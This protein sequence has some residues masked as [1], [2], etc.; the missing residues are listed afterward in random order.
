VPVR[1]L[2]SFSL[3]FSWAS[4]WF[5]LLLL[6][7]LVWLR[8]HLNLSRAGHDPVLLVGDPGPAD[9]PWPRLSV[10]VAAKDEEENI[11]ACLSG[12]LSQDYPELELIVIN[13]RS[14]DRTGEI[15]DAVAARDARVKAV[16]VR[17]LPPGW[18]GKNH[19]MHVG[20]QRATGDYLCFTDADCHYHATGLL[21]AA[22]RYA[23]AEQIEFLSVLPE[24]EAHT[25]WERV[26]QPPAGAIMVF[27]FAPEQ[28]NSPA[29]R[30][31]YA[32]GAFMLLT[33]AAYQKL[34]GH[35]QFRGVLNEDMH[36]A[37]EAKRTG[38]SLRVLRGGGLYSVRMYVG[39]Q[40][41]W[42]GWSR[43]FYGCF[44]TWGRL[45]ASAIFLSVFSLSPWIA[46]LSSPFLGRV[47]PGIAVAALVAIS[48]Q[49]SV[50]RR[51]YRL[52]AMPPNWAL[53]YPLG[54]ALCLAITCNAMTRLAGG[55]T[56]WRGTAYTGGAQTSP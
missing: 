51:F 25:F 5:W 28:V 22:V 24:L 49:Q 34:G 38:V 43:I 40:Q 19:A 54:A 53:S 20:V 37:R 36:L 1:D 21:R 31:A 18:A 8:R 10:L 35:Q 32:N 50:L 55:Q 39:L 48:A 41:I 17:E 45:L 15:I 6:I 56:R 33:Q 47:G 9:P 7:G 30:C 27:W 29:S 14:R 42:R 13:D 44:G 16:H 26:V 2:L 46:L 52:C 12:L 23:H 4:V 11:E 3:H